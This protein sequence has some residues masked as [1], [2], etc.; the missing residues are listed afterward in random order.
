MAT[1]FEPI[2][3]SQLFRTMLIRLIETHSVLR[4][5]VQTT[6]S[7]ELKLCHQANAYFLSE[8]ESWLT[9]LEEDTDLTPSFS[10]AQSV[11]L[12][13]GVV[14]ALRQPEPLGGASPPDALTVQTVRLRG[15][16][17]ARS[18]RQRERTS[19]DLART[20]DGKIIFL[21]QSSNTSADLPLNTGSE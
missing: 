7:R 3:A 9:E 16:S 6:L 8:I 13:V 10:V 4:P 12:R 21:P 11:E 19:L 14:S 15:T 2:P 5:I 1:P 17:R 20:S 18:S